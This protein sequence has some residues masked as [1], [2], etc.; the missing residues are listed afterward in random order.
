MSDEEQ[1]LEAWGRGD[2]DAG[3]VLF[4]RY[5]RVLARFFANKAGPEAPELIQQTFLR[6][7]ESRASYAGTA[8]FRA[9]LLGIARNVFFKHLRRRYQWDARVDAGVTSVEQ[10]APSHTSIV[11]RRREEQLLL[12][13][14]RQLPIEQQMLLEWYFWD[15]LTAP[16]IAE[17]LAIPI[18]TVRSRLGR[19]REV[20]ADAMKRAR[21]VPADDDG[22]ADLEAWAA[23]IR[24]QLGADA[25]R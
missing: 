2:E 11:A 12:V 17:V 1:L 9:F 25:P 10:L 6:C 22:P 7:V 19:A 18:G 5:Y 4:D 3:R 16:E 15:D 21:V 8:S 13:S 24:A 23:G 14:L 20:L